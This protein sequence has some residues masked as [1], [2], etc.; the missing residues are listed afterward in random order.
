MTRGDRR[1]F[2][3]LAVTVGIALGALY[4]AGVTVLWLNP[5]TE[6]DRRCLSKSLAEMQEC[7][8]EHYR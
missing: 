5:P 8:N 6:L 7:F 1:L 2:L 3:R 4:L